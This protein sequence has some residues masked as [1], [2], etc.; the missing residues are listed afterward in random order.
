MYEKGRQKN[1]GR[2]FKGSNSKRNYMLQVTGSNY[3]TQS[4]LCSFKIEKHLIGGRVKG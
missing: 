3:M 4:L 1:A 2:S